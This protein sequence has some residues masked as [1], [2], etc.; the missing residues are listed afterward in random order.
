MDKR[1]DVISDIITDAG[2][3]PAGSTNFIMD[4]ESWHIPLT[5]DGQTINRALCTMDSFK[6]NQGDVPFIIRLFENPK[7]NIFPGSVTLDAH[8]IIHVLLGRGLLPKDEAF[9]IGF[10]MG[11]SKKLSWIQKWIFK[12]ATRYLYPEGYTFGEDEHE[13]FEAGLAIGTKMECKDLTTVDLSEYIHYTI[14]SARQIL[15]IDTDML[16]QY[17]NIER[18]KYTSPES[19]RLI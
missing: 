9:V 5:E 17:Y 6:L 18:G 15:N 11:T 10:T 2:S 12:F 19:Q 4:A 14:Y 3:T 7:Y 13:I 1:V 8:D 16:V